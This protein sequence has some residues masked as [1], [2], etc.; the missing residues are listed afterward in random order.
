MQ[1]LENGKK[2]LQKCWLF[3]RISIGSNKKTFHLLI[4]G[5]VEDHSFSV[6]SLKKNL[7]KR[8]NSLKTLTSM[9]QYY[10]LVEILA[11]FFKKKNAILKL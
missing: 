6:T 9:L 2:G 10:A 5:R 3:L 1:K 11:G 7:L 4:K 8:T